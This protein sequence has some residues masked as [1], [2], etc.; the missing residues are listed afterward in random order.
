[1]GKG[2]RRRSYGSYQSRRRKKMVREALSGWWIVLGM[3]A[4]LWFMEWPGLQD[5]RDTEFFDV[6]VRSGMS[7]PYLYFGF[8]HR[9]RPPVSGQ[10]FAALTALVIWAPMLPISRRTLMMLLL[11]MTWADTGAAVWYRIFRQKS[12]GVLG[13]GA[14]HMGMMVLINIGVRT[15]TMKGFP[16]WFPSLVFAIAVAWVCFRLL[17]SGQVVL[18]DDVLSERV[19]VV[20]GACFVGFFLVWGSCVCANYGLDTSSPKRYD[21]VVEEKDIS[22]GRTTSYYI[23]VT[24]QGERTRFEI[25]Q[26]DYYRVEIGDECIVEWYRGFLGEPYHTIRLE[27]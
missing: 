3:F 13:W 10:V 18:K 24:V 8:L 12:F 17:W 21:A 19:A 14:V 11:L 5:F 25:T 16:F 15:S 26:S 9:K 6:L 22:G 20:I 7:L 1:M 4:L 27:E 2:K 23:Y